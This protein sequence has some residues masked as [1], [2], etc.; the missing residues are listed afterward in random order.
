MR[1]MLTDLEREGLFHLQEE[2][3]S[4]WKRIGNLLE[5]SHSLYIS[6]TQNIFHATGY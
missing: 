4:Q 6:K 5:D 3:N 1:F 2:T